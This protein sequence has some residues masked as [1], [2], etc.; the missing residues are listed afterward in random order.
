MRWVALLV[1]VSCLT[2]RQIGQAQQPGSRVSG[3]ITILE[4]DT[5][6]TTDL[7]DAVVYLDEC[8]P[9]AFRPGDLVDAVITD[10]RGYDVVAR[11]GVS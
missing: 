4:K 6:A 1:A 5:K 2:G 9:S 10:A 8:D 7:G 3:R 11:P